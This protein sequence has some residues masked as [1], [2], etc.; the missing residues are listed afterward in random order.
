MCDPLLAYFIDEAHE[1]WRRQFCV[2]HPELRERVKRE[3]Q[4]A[5]TGERI[6]V[7]DK[8]ELPNSTPTGRTIDILKMRGSELPS[9]FTNQMEAVGECLFGTVKSG[10]TDIEVL[11]SIAHNKWMGMNASLKPVQPRL[12]VQY[13][14]LDEIEKEKD[15]V[16][17]RIALRLARVS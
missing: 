3:V 14:Q 8:D 12:F 5:N 7:N 11:A 10:T 13:E 16:F 2:E 6:W 9:Q 17:A 1:E 4:M 15:R